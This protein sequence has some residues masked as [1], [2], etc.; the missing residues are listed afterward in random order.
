MISL[1]AEALI[2]DALDVR[3]AIQGVATKL[4]P[5]LKS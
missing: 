5:A 1:T 4:N 2:A 3:S